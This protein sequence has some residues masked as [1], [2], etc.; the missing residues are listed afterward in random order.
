MSQQPNAPAPSPMSAP[1]QQALGLIN[2][3]RQAEAI[4]ALRAALAAGQGG[5]DVEH[6][7]GAALAESG[8]YAEA[9]QHLQIA[10]QARP[11]DALARYNLGN[12]F[13]GGGRF[14]EATRAY[15]AA[16]QLQPGQPQAQAALQRMQTSGPPPSLH[17]G[18][19]GGQLGGQ[20][21]PAAVATAR[22]PAPTRPR[23]EAAQPEGDPFMS[24]GAGALV[25]LL[26]AVGLCF[27]LRLF[28]SPQ[29]L[30][31][32]KSDLM[33][34]L[35]WSLFPWLFLLVGFVVAKAD[36]P[37]ALVLGPVAGLL[38]GVL[39]AVAAW[40]LKVIPPAAVLIAG[41][42]G[43]GLVCAG[44]TAALGRQVPLSQGFGMVGAIVLLVLVGGNRFLNQCLVKGAAMREEIK[45]AQGTTTAMDTVRV[46]GVTVELWD[47]AGKELMFRTTTD[48]NGRYKLSNLPPGTYTMQW[49]LPDQDAEGIDQ[50]H[51]EVHP[52][53]SMTAQADGTD[54]VL[55]SVTHD[56]GSIFVEGPA[57]AGGVGAPTTPG[58]LFGPTAG[59]VTPV[60]PGDFGGGGMGPG[61]V[62]LERARGVS[63]QGS[64]RGQ[65]PDE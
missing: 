21:P 48:Q 1:A 35:V 54:I 59:P 39:A 55:P 40:L 26:G 16:L 4:E 62:M 32:L 60:V 43:L 14:H 53:R 27:A 51:Q 11:Q 57:G 9:V 44:A 49:Y 65:L 28:V 2:Q 47:S 12:A 6:V 25:G 46:P 64:T 50:Q 19:A 58:A 63:G 7:L 30:D 37:R 24:V 36:A 18:I 5:F 20:P 38:S 10:V 61:A 45:R 56:M 42:A 13:E 31:E 41:L 3:G 34:P 23:Q 22:H 33:R 8:Q 17:Q 29:A 52:T 15:E